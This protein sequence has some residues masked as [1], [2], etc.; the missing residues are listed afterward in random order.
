MGPVSR[1]LGS[2]EG[3]K[4]ERERVRFGFRKIPLAAMWWVDQ[5]GETGWEPR[6]SWGR[7][8]WK[9]GAVGKGRGD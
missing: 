9:G 8:S 7:K 3:F 6:E 2:Q 5:R 4:Q 1:T